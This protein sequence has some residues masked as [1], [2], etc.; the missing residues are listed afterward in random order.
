[1]ENREHEP[2]PKSVTQAFINTMPVGTIMPFAGD[3]E[4]AR[5]LNEYGWYLCDGTGVGLAG[6]QRLFNILEETCGKKNMEIVLPDLRGTFLRG[7]D[8]LDEKEGTIRDPESGVR[9]RHNNGEIIGNKVLSRQADALKSHRH[10]IEHGKGSRYAD[11]VKVMMGDS[12]EFD[13]FHKA[14]EGQTIS[15]ADTGGK[16]SRPVNVSV[17]YIIYVGLNNSPL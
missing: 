15:T 2:Q 1:M 7:V 17:N 13:N 16:E 4:A 8:A 9:T 11:T 10:E 5:E 14:A 12:H 6:H 3:A